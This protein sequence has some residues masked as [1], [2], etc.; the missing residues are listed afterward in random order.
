LKASLILFY[1]SADNK[2]IKGKEWDLLPLFPIEKR[3][4]RKGNPLGSS[5]NL[6][7]RIVS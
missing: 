2:A 4:E 5:E 7:I 1:T 6:F 3:K